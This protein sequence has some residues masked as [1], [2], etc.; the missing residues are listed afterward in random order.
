[1]ETLDEQF[2]DSVFRNN[3]QKHIER[4]LKD[5]KFMKKL[6]AECEEYVKANPEEF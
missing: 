1:M 5:S 4:R 3:H 6:N 2:D